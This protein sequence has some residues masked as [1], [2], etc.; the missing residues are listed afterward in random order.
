M[1]LMP[2]EIIVRIVVVDKGAV[3]FEVRN[4]GVGLAVR[5]DGVILDG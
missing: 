4:A 2:S 3:R 1:V 5:D